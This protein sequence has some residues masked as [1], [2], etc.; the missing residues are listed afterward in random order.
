MTDADVRPA[1]SAAVATFLG[2]MAL[3][4]V[5]TSAAWVDPVLAVIL[6][7][8]AGGL[9]VRTGGAALW[10]TLR[11]GRAPSARM[12]AFGV[13]LVPMA[14]LM[15][16]LAVLTALFAPAEAIAGV[17]PTSASL[18]QL[19][20]VFAD[21]SA[22]L[23]EQA[24]PALP[25]T[26]LL[27]LTALF[28]GL[29]AVLVDL[30]TVAGRQATLAGLA[31]LVLYC[32]PVA[33]VTGGIGL[34]ALAAPAAGLA[35]LM[36]TDQRSRLA[37]AGR[38]NGG[39]AGGRTAVRIGL[40]ALVAGLLL[41][42]LVPTL[43]EGSLATGLGGG[44]GGATGTSID[45]VATMQGQ[46]TLPEPI[47]LLRLEASVADPGHLRAVAIDEYD[48]EF[49]WS[50][51]NLSGEES[52]A[53]DDRLAPLPGRQTSR[54]V[55]ASIQV[56]EH[57]DRFLPTL[58][59]PQSIR[60]DG[61]DRAGADGWRFDPGTGTI[62]GRE[63]TSAGL[64]YTVT[65]SEPRPTLDQL[66]GAGQ[67]RPDDPVQQLF[68][69]LPLLDPRVTDLLAE[70]TAGA[71]TPYER[72][73]SIQDF[74]TDRDNGFVYSLSTSPGTTGD[75]L[76]D[77]LRLRRGYCE[78]YAGAMAVMVRAAGVPARVALG[79]TPGTVQED[80]SRLI[81]SDDAHA[82]VEVYFEGLGWVPFDPTPIAQDR[83]VDLPWAPRAGEEDQPDDR[84]AVPAP[85]APSRPLP[86]APQDRFEGGAPGVQGDQ[87]AEGV[88]W[89]LVGAA[90]LAVLIGALVAA[91]AAIRALQ[92]R[93][94]VATGTAGALW[95]E[96]TA[97]A[98]DA[99]MRLHPAWTPRR[100]AH[101]LGAALGRTG[102]PGGGADAVLRL[103][104]A[105]ESASYGRAAG[106]RT[107]ADL[108]GAL[109]TARRGLLAALPRGARVRARLWPASLVSGAGGRLA[110]AMTR[111]LPR[112]L[113]PRTSTA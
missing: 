96:L 64:R 92:R 36:W 9:L 97:T 72:V 14:Q 44:P 18:E 4:P 104:L 17:L 71:S 90:G 53:D 7:V 49:G 32:V 52:I 101:E 29:I 45:P 24:T 79:Y 26:G 83:A 108:A 15:L 68:T 88:R 80:G 25:L 41:G 56:I 57:D 62:Y 78:Q 112:R 63:V 94:R 95:D 23:R 109:H 27:S 38:R 81:T 31:L 75:D 70:V 66:T 73:R 113:R 8:L 93:R 50:M 98:L 12:S 61:Q 91:P 33:T 86:A 47:D 28:V 55:A 20:A 67:L 74:L 103:A 22:E 48:S 87:V 43:P 35:L 6:T 3:A 13:A 34:V 110:T 85:T 51:S 42:P 39:G 2:A 69:A 100:T 99:G 11:H 111:R 65:A 82:W 60:L 19:V 77:F 16:L 10:A 21:G 58:F 89:P 30:A 54:P 84:A 107:P 37:S 5:Y 105:E 59:S 1:V 40:A 76:V 46:L 106:Q 102:T